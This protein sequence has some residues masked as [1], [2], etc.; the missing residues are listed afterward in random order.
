MKAFEI[1]SSDINIEDW[2]EFLVEDRELNPSFYQDKDQNEAEWLR[3][4]EMNLEY[5]EDE[6]INLNIKLNNPILILADLGLWNGRRPAYKIISSGN[7]KDILQSCM[8]GDTSCRWYCDGKNILCREAHHDGVNH[9]VYR[10]IRKPET[11]ERF[12][13]NFVAGRPISAGSVNYYTRSIATDVG[14]VYGFCK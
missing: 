2:R 12:L 1:W 8:D 13:Q 3:V 11:L 10:E 4:N 9:Y 7:V 14:R 6:R 5:L